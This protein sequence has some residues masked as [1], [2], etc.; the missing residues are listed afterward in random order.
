MSSSIRLRSSDVLRQASVALASTEEETYLFPRHTTPLEALTAVINIIQDSLPPPLLL[1]PPRTKKRIENMKKSTLEFKEFQ[2]NTE[3]NTHARLT[4]RA[5]PGCAPAP[6]PPNKKAR[7]AVR[8][9]A[10]ESNNENFEPY[11]LSLHPQPL[12][13]LTG[14][15]FVMRG[16][17]GDESSPVCEVAPDSVYFDTCSHC[18]YI[19]ADILPDEFRAYLRDAEHDPYRISNN[20]QVQV[21]ATICFSNSDHKLSFTAVITPPLSLPNNLSGVL[22][23]Q[24]G[25]IN[26]LGFEATPKL[27]LDKLGRGEGLIDTGVLPLNSGDPPDPELEILISATKQLAIN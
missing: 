12:P 7:E 23:G 6:P 1:V 25:M 3:P 22:L 11:Y 24:H 2:E 14:C 26:R 17:D 19:T 21:D 18:T 4:Y 27:V 5:P 8:R 9:L 16:L 15:V 10:L 20:A 13:G